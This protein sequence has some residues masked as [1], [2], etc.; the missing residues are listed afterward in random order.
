MGEGDTDLAPPIQGPMGR[1]NLA[2]CAEVEC[3]ELGG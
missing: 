1:M 3:Q 2:A